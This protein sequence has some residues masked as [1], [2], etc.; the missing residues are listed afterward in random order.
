MADSVDPL[1]ADAAR[2][3][4]GGRFDDAAE[5]YQQ[6]LETAPHTAPTLLLSGRLRLQQG[7]MCKPPT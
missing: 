5:C 6:A 3:Q 7:G 4:L 2:L 1:R